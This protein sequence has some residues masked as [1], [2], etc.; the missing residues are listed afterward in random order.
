MNNMS[1]FADVLY[2]SGLQD[3][4]FVGD[5]FTWCN[6]RGG[7]ETILERLDR[8]LCSAD[9]QLNFPEAEVQHLEF[10]GSDH[11][12]IILNLNQES[13]KTRS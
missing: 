2:D 7:D 9:W 8:F 13:N 6:R 1:A 11:R 12:E 4:S 3:M 5:Q 10:F